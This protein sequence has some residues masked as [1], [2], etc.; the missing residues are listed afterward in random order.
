M[1]RRKSVLRT[2]SRAR[3]YARNIRIHIT[4]SRRPPA[5]VRPTAI[6]VHLYIRQFLID[7]H[8]NVHIFR[9][10]VM[11]LKSLIEGQNWDQSNWEHMQKYVHVWHLLKQRLSIGS[12]RVCF[13]RCLSIVS[14]AMLDSLW[15]I[16]LDFLYYG[17]RRAIETNKQALLYYS[18]VCITSMHVS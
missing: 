6:A 10:H 16:C 15:A 9:W 5:R 18:W 2:W 17:L 3:I 7:V 13:K 12:L 4:W 11:A 1:R 14:S 8:V